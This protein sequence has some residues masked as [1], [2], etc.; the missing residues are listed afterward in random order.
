M[1]VQRQL[2]TMVSSHFAVIIFTGQ[3]SITPEFLRTGLVYV[4]SG[5]LPFK[6]RRIAVAVFL[7]VKKARHHPRND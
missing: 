6:T 5:K 1:K 7:F 3:L 2:W 4:C